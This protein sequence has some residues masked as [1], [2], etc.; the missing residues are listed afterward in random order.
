MLNRIALALIIW[1]F[2][3]GTA[4]A[5]AS[6]PE[7]PRPASLE[8]AIRF[9]REVFLRWEG[10]QIVYTDGRDLSRV[11]EVRRLPPA[12]GTAARERE[13]E[14]LRADWKRELLADL[15][16]LAGPA[17]D[18]DHLRGRPLRLFCLWGE[19][20]DA[21]TYARAAENLRSQRGIREAFTGGVGR[22]ARYLEDFRAIF[23]EEGVP[24]DLVYLPHV[25]SSYRWNA[26]SSAG[27]LGMWQFMSAT[28]RRYM[29]VDDAVDERLDP[30]TAARGAARYLKAA[31]AEL[32]TWPLAVTS[33]NHGVDGI[34]NAV[35]ATGTTDLAVIIETYDG[36]LF[37]FAGRNFYPELLAAREAS[38]A[39]LADPGD[40]PLDEPVAFDEFQLPAYVKLPVLARTLGASPAEITSL[41]PALK[42]HARSGV[43]Y[44][45]KGFTVKLPPGRGEGAGSLFASLPAKERP[46]KPPPRTYRV[47]RGDTLGA[48]AGR[49]KTS[50]RIL[51]R[52]NGIRN[53]NQ[54][55]AG[56]LLKLPH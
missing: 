44:L 22:S 23:R 19:S 9:W 1:C 30:H 45:P 34:K 49:Y 31:R 15:E 12:N 6:S 14:R 21:A 53:P 40:I 35:R 27:A 33:Y 17:V 10:D 24:E 50:M 7:L 26:R 52:L 48:I 39:F 32:G 55:R 43:H 18:Y 47:K 5:A 54:L 51:Q 4:E 41:N 56:T 2:A 36:P 28:A 8:P 3:S 16:Q 11:Y 38:E 29:M 46:L 37:G 20:R 25:E 13:R 42:K